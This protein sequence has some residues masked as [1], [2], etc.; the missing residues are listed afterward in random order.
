MEGLTVGQIAVG[1]TLVAGLI[2]SVTLIVKNL[3]N[4]FKKMIQPEFDGLKK[5]IQGISDNV[6][7]VDIQSCKNYLV[8]VL[9][10]VEKGNTLDEI[11][12]ERL[13]EQFEHY[14]TI[15]GNSYIRR[16]FEQLQ[17]EGKL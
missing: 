2:T 5:D 13:Y 8:T 16:K 6:K 14:K 9:S 7:N 12:R 17:T 11:E 4:W 10:S 1:L 15:G 3:K